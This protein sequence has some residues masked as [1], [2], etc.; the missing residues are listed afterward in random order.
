[1]LREQGS[2]HGRKNEARAQHV[3]LTL[4]AAMSPRPARSASDN[5]RSLTAIPCLLG[6]ALYWPRV[7]S[8]AAEAYPLVG[9]S[10]LSHSESQE[11]S[12]EKH[13]CQ[14]TGGPG[15]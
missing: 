4:Q 13:L 10:N 8:G 3:S 9:L 7:A 1:M 6:A 14:L 5:P 2:A 11:F 12:P 15:G